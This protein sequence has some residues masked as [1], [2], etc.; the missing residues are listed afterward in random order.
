MPVIA[1]SPKGDAAIQFLQRVRLSGSPRPL[2]GL[3]M[4]MTG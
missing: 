1:R 3:A 4:T 2:R